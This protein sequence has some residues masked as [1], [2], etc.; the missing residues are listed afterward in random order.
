MFHTRQFSIL[1]EDIVNQSSPLIANAIDHFDEHGDPV[2]VSVSYELIQLLSDQLYQSP[3]KAIEEL[4]VN[5]YD[6]DATECY[7]YVPSPSET[8]KDFAIVFD[9]GIGM[10]LD[11]LVELWKIGESNKRT[12]EIQSKRKRK[13][14]GKFGIGKL[15][16]HAIAN[17]LTYVTKSSQ[18]S[19]LS[20]TVNFT[21]FSSSRE[22]EV[23]AIRLPV[24]D[25][26][27]WDRF[28]DESHISEI[29]QRVGVNP[30]MLSKTGSWTIAILEDLKTKA[31]KIKEA[32]LKWVLSTAMPL[33]PDFCLHLNG[34][35]IQSSKE[36][37]EEIVT[38]DLKDLPKERL[39]SLQKSTSENWSVQGESLKSDSFESGIT[40]TVK[41]TEKS[42]Y[43]GKSDDLQRSHGFFIQVLGRLINGDDPLFGLQPL[44]YGTF[45]RLRADIDADD[46]DQGLKA[47]R[48]TIEESELKEKFR[49]VL[50]EIFNEAD[51]RYQIKTDDTETTAQPK[52]GEKK[53]VS[54]YQVEYPIADALTI[55][56]TDTQGTEADEDWFYIEIDAD[57]DLEAL[58]QS[59]YTTPR[60]KF[61]YQYRGDNLA[62]RL[63]RFNPRT[64]TFWLNQDHELVK[65]YAGDGQAKRLLEDFVTAEALLEI[66]LRE[67]RLPPH[68]VG[69]V[70]EQRDSLLRRLVKDKTYTLATIGKLLRDAAAD[71]NELEVMI[72]V[73]TRALGFVATHI[74]GSGEPDG[75]ARFIEYPGGEK[76]ITLE[77]KSSDEVPSLTTIDFAGLQSHVDKNSADGCLL[78]APEYP[79]QSAADNEAARRAENQRISCW[80]VKQ[81]A[82]FVESA[83]S[84]QFNAIDLLDIVLNCFAPDNVTAK[85]EEMTSQPSKNKSPLYSAILQSLQKLEGRMIDDLRNVG[86]ITTE[87]S[88]LSEFSEITQSDIR[89]A[90]RDM[91]SLSD[92]GMMLK[93]D[94]VIV[95]VAPE[96]LARRLSDFTKQ[97]IKSRRISE[98]RNNE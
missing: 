26:D 45:N 31:R 55:Q 39:K 8:N 74:S 9:D 16:A 68:I 91:V 78:V 18:G 85:L 83:E 47:S 7:V 44:R 1:G 96:E 70:L 50:R 15:A 35:E 93:G 63:V 87:V 60:N 67:S 25:I 41:V 89:E 3:L 64:S 90:V 49:S 28:C 82:A 73:A 88:R 69:E 13:Q 24:R 23:N 17:Q 57:T 43:G 19:I 22:E 48:D 42:L 61:R 75:I 37:Y 27:D 34:Q 59:L 14:I 36:D 6:A 54:P 21:K 84:R 20:V 92:G 10:D 86:M 81:F 38:F 32:N 46:L 2:Q 40:G 94:D 53:I 77:A 66:Y 72:V 98:F 71:M 4:V 62:S 12:D 79:G 30:E 97:D 51:T 33:R 65:E 5:A 76:K 11:G 58:I 56:K 52:E 95:H 80:T 29:L